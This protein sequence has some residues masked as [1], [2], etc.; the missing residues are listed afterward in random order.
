MLAD[1]T[2]QDTFPG[3]Y[4]ADNINHHTLYTSQHKYITA[5]NGSL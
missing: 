2:N 5:E 1:Q 3:L 4:S